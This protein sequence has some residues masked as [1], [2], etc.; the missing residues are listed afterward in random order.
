MNFEQ[1]AAIVFQWVYEIVDIKYVLDYFLS[2]PIFFMVFSLKWIQVT[3]NIFFFQWE[4]KQL[5]CNDRN[6][7]IILNTLLR[8]ER[9]K[10]TMFQ[11]LPGKG[12]MYKICWQH[13]VIFY[14]NWLFFFFVET[15]QQHFIWVNSVIHWLH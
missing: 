15:V 7:K 5:L 2:F 14:C 9:R 10:N 11:N 12:K 8:T 4:L 1:S 3:Q 6:R 13:Q